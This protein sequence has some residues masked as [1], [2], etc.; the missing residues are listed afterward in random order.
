MWFLQTWI[1]KLEVG[2]GIRYLKIAVVC[3]AVMMLAVGYNWHS[4][5]NMSAQEA[6]DAAQV[7]RNLAEGKGYTTLFIRPLSLYLVETRNKARSGA[8]LNS[9]NQVSRIQNLSPDLANPPVYPLVLAGWMKVYSAAL[10]SAERV[11]GFSPD[12]L[13]WELPSFNTASDNPLWQKRG[14]F[15]WYPHDFFIALFNEL[16][17]GVVV[18]MT[19]LLARRLFDTGVAWLSSGLVLGCELLWRFSVSGLSTLLLL[20]I[21][22]GLVWCLVLIETEAR[23][24]ERGHSYLL[25]LAMAAGLLTG[26]GALT[27]YA[28]GWTI[29]PVLLF[30]ILF[31]GSRAKM[32]CLTTLAAFLIVLGPWAYRNFTVSGTPF[33]TA[34]FA[35]IEG[36]P[37]FT[38]H[39]LERSLAPNFSDVSPGLLKRKLLTHSREILQHEL[40]TLGG[41][42][43][44]AL[45]LAGLMIGF[46]RLAVRRMRYFLLFCLAVLV[47]VQALGRTQLSEDSPETNSENLLILLVPLVFMYGTSLFFVLL[48]QINFVFQGLRHAVIALFAG[49]MCLPM[50]YAFLLPRL[51]P[52]TS[53]TCF[54]PYIQQVSG[55]MKEDELMMSDVP[56]AVAWYGHRPCVWLT[57]DAQSDFFAIHNHH[58]PIQ[59]LYLTSVPVDTR[60][61]TDWLRGNGG[62]WSAFVLG[63]MINHEI[64]PNFPL[65][66]APNGFLPDRLFLSDKE[67]WK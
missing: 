40:P 64:P 5:R 7:A 24:P 18:V 25:L 42:W 59:A 32:L 46:H 1:H 49:V 30:L 65:R 16:L 21:F 36:T 13:K 2:P 55:W 8:P 12:S 38:Q 35:A 63:A 15:W 45:F 57:L 11:R 50:V 67:R 34:S 31:S 48:D 27:R 60:S 17:L 3:L 33:G 41:N 26:A 23:E 37:E 43:M 44:T 47:V 54:P 4:Y 28:F 10:K 61:L 14:G 52:V 66:H 29:I 9:T 53:P 56:W 19:F 22:M 58:K 62:G 20:V 39:Q 6:M 51:V